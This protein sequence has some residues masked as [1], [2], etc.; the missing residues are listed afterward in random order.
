MAWHYQRSAIVYQQLRTLSLPP[1]FPDPI[2]CPVKVGK[3][4]TRGKGVH[5]LSGVAGDFS[6][7]DLVYVVIEVHKA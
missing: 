4:F 2:E 7:G 1:S 6:L 5:C 3:L